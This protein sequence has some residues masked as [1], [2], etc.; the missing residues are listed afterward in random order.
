MNRSA[1]RLRGA[2]KQN[3]IELI[4][5]T[6]NDKALLE[7]CVNDLSY[8]TEFTGWNEFS[9][10][11][12]QDLLDHKELPQN[13]SKENDR[14]YIIKKEG[15]PVGYCKLYEGAMNDPNKVFLGYMGIMR[16]YQK[17]GIGR[18][19]Y[20][21]LEEE[22]KNSKYTTIRLNVGTRNIEAFAFWIR[23]GYRKIVSVVKY[24]NGFMDIN[25]EKEI[26]YL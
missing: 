26:T 4:E 25:L 20:R 13:G 24:D 21:V 10:D 9:E 22:I 17:R 3:S 14:V 15:I 11:E 1:N 2:I 7:E 6:Q 8:I 16:E 19:V 12:A 18:E 5:A 23:N